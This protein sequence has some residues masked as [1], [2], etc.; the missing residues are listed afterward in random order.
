MQVARLVLQ[1]VL[2]IALT[3]AVQ[4]WDESR[5]PAPR[6]EHAWNTATWGAALFWYGPLSMLAWGWVTRREKGF[7]GVLRGLGGMLLGA[8]VGLLVA[9][10]GQGVDLA[11]AWAFD[12]PIEAF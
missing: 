7:V 10:V 6:R 11:F 8:L 3:Y 9:L 4:R 2:G 12:L 1:L 5:L